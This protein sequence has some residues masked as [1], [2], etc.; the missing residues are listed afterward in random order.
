VGTTSSGSSASAALKRSKIAPALAALAGPVTR[1]SA[2]TGSMARAPDGSACSRRAGPE[3]K[4]VG[5]PPNRLREPAMRHVHLPVEHSDDD[6]LL[7]G[8]V[9]ERLESC[10]LYVTWSP[11]GYR[12][13]S[14]DTLWRAAQTSA[15]PAPAA[16]VVAPTAST[17]L[18]P[19]AALVAFLAAALRPRTS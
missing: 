3:P 5:N 12:R 1:V 14:V 17:P 4:G 8:H 6:L 11:G 15:L 10:A 9:A 19:I 7:A 13:P 16:P 18:G 2:I